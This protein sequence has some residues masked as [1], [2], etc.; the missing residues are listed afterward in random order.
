MN[1]HTLNQLTSEHLWQYGL[2][3]YSR[4]EVN[5]ACL[6]LQDQFNGNV[7]LLIALSWLD[8]QDIGFCSDPS[9]LKQSPQMQSAQKQWTQIQHS[10][11]PTEALLTPF[12]ALRRKTKQHLPTCIYQDVLSFELQ[13]ERQQQNDILNAILSLELSKTD[14]AHLVDNY[15]HQ[16]GAISLIKILNKPLPKKT[17]SKISTKKKS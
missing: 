12:R 10:L 15:C 4:P 17:L 1:Q 6:I 11:E 13:L 16:L 7:N 3:Y 2:L 14:S 5:Q 8:A 9:S